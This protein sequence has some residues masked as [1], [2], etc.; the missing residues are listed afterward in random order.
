MSILISMNLNQSVYLSSHH[1]M[2]WFRFTIIDY[3]SLYINLCD[4]NV[5]FENTGFCGVT[6]RTP[7]QTVTSLLYQIYCHINT[8]SYLSILDTR[9]YMT[10][11]ITSTAVQGLVPEIS[12]RSNSN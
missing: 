2:L 5:L 7:A 4:S 8:S 3:N 6:I 1:Y 9:E 10:S 12:N 11:V